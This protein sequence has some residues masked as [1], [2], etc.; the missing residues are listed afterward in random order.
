MLFRVLDASPSTQTKRINQQMKKLLACSTALAMLASPA[1]ATPLQPATIINQTAPFQQ[2]HFVISELILTIPDVGTSIHNPISIGPNQ[3][4]TFYDYNA[5]P[6]LLSVTLMNKY[7]TPV[8][9]PNKFNMCTQ[10]TIT[11]TET[12]LD[13]YA[14]T[15]S[16]K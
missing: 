5:R 11:V 13:H 8:T 2:P 15:Y 1:L 6:C 14:F 10:N 16:V 7:G 9:A 12:S 3:Y 4:A